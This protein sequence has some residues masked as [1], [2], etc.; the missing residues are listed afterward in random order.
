MSETSSAIL[1]RLHLTSAP[2][3]VYR[4]LSTD[5]G[6][7]AFWAE[8]AE[9]EAGRIVFA[10]PSGLR[11]VSTILEAHFPHKFVLE[12]I[13]GSTVTFELS[14]D[15]QGGTDLLLTAQGVPLAEHADVLAGWVSVLMLLKAAVDHGVDLRNHDPQRSWETGY[16]DN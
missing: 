2:E 10:F 12:Y 4:M 14:P 11:Y 16:A 1:W 7:S 15:G 3:K 8:S 6:R 9:E 5:Q 13:T